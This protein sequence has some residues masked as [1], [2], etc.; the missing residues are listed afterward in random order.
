MKA[1]TLGWFEVGCDIDD[2]LKAQA[3][4]APF[5]DRLLPTMESAVNP[6]WWRE[7]IG[8]R[9]THCEVDLNSAE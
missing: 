5:G 4:P 9:V 6:S 3:A 8:P 2:L 1:E 7:D